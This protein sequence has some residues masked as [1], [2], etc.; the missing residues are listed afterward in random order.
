MKRTKR[1]G[2]SSASDQKSKV[3]KVQDAVEDIR[4]SDDDFATPKQTKSRQLNLG[5]M[6]SRQAA[7]KPAAPVDAS[8]MFL[9]KT[10][11]ATASAAPPVVVAPSTTVVQPPAASAPV[12]ST[13]LVITPKSPL[14]KPAAT[15]AAPAKTAVKTAAKK[16][17]AKPPAAP[18]A[19]SKLVIT[20]KPAPAKKGGAASEEHATVISDTEPSP[21]VKKKKRPAAATAGKNDNEPPPKAAKGRSGFMAFMNRGPPPMRGKKEMPTGAP[22]CLANKTFVLSGVLESLERDEASD[23]IKSYG[24]R[25]TG[26][27]SKKTTYLVTGEGAGESK[28]Q[29]AQDMGVTVIDEDGLFDLIRNG[30][31]V[32]E[33]APKVKKVTKKASAASATTTSPATG[34]AL[35]KSSSGASAVVT[36]LPPPL[37]KRTS[38][39]SVAEQA[40][41]QLWTD[42]FAPQSLRELVGNQAPVQ[43]LVDW[44]KRWD[45]VHLGPAEA[46]PPKSAG[47][48]GSGLGPSA[49]AALISGPPGIGKTTTAVLACR[50]AGLEPIELNASDTRSKGALKGQVTSLLGSR[51][52][53]SLAKSGKACLIMDEVDGMSGGDRGGAAELTQL[54]KTSKIPVICIGNDMGSPKMRSL[55]NVCFELPF[56]RPTVQQI[57]ERLLSVARL[58]GIATDK[59]SMEKL[60]ELTHSDIRQSLHMLQLWHSRSSALTFQDVRSYV[61][62]ASKDFTTNPFDAA[63]SLVSAGDNRTTSFGRKVEAYFVDSSLLPL[64]VQEN[65]LMT[66]GPDF[67]QYLAAADSISDGD[68]V[69]K[70]MRRGQRWE[71][72]TGHALLSCARPAT[73]TCG[74]LRGM[75]TFPQWLGK[76]SSTSKHMRLLNEVS[77]HA[78]TSISGDRN[79]VNLEYVPVLAR[80]LADPLLKQGAAGAQEVVD[81]LDEYHLNRD[82]WASI[83][84]LGNLISD[85][86][87]H[88]DAKA[89][90]AFTRKYNAAHP[91]VKATKQ[92]GGAAASGK[93]KKKTIVVA[94][95]GEEGQ[96]EED[97]VE[98]DVA[99]VDETIFD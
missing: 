66:S 60:A 49:R 84:E 10:K 16:K 64:M 47:G 12:P 83:A 13:K 65:Y 5:Q 68:I 1:A 25:V 99:D 92:A 40:A 24:G 63:R 30:V 59:P 78:R 75:I 43:R 53:G 18:S 4:N 8:R 88:V 85:P 82:D 52:I 42:R 29:K 61:Q 9:G 74:T 48:F 33:A 54:I 90:G 23:L 26:N 6:F 56:R 77:T 96:E 11:T 98:A 31:S 95:D 94:E 34:G 22:N 37:S 3:A 72:M 97:V 36:P 71:L 76:N 41:T 73:L 27:V 67:E 55:K 57:G 17:A 50:E 91:A 28:S 62:A 45:A 70:V 89:K 58:Q 51:T 32:P 86:Y 14:E 46:R 39:M 35:A 15:T 79:S 87:A 20:P 21:D 69:D 93:G 2:E 80:V 7:A 81:F 38:S 19:A 44:L